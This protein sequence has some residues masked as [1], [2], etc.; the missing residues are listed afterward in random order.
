MLVLLL[1]AAL[2]TAFAIFATQNTTN[3]DLNFGKYFIPGV[4]IYLVVLVPLLM[5][6]ILAYLLHVM[7]ILSHDMTIE[8]QKKEIKTLKRDLAEANKRAHKLDLENMKFK[9]KKGVFD[10]D[11]FD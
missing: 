8:D 7:K 3:V 11:S 5:G 10:E 1:T 4:P 6:L 2:G 9:K